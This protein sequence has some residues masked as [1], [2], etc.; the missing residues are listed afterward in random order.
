VGSKEK[1]K[2]RKR[3]AKKV[4]QHV[5][6]VER[7]SNEKY[8]KGNLRFLFPNMPIAEI[9]QVSKLYPLSSI[10]IVPFTNV[11]F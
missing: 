11:K 1:K 8:H 4:F 10:L 6:T 2:E 7:K 9:R 3:E 5:W